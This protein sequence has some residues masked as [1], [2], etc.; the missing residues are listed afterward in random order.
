[1]PLPRSLWLLA[2]LMSTP[3]LVARAIPQAATE[4]FGRVLDLADGRPVS[5]VTITLEA[6]S[7]S[8]RSDNTGRY[9]LSGA[10]SGP[11]VLLARRVAYAVAR[12]SITDGR[13][14]HRFD[15]ARRGQ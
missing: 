11:Q 8:T 13:P 4:V 15:D 9:R 10:P 12:V 1:M 5:G 7:A 6:T 14:L 3:T 2:A